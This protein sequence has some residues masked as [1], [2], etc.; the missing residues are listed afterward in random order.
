MGLV[1]GPDPD[2]V[3]LVGTFSEDMITTGICF[4]FEDSCLG[5]KQIVSDVNVS[6][7]N[8][9]VFAKQIKG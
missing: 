8:M 9:L 5:R 3:I 2:L 4:S 6:H 7:E 1:G